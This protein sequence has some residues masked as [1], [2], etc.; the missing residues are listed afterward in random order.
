MAKNIHLIKTPDFNPEKK[1]LHKKIAS[2][3]AHKIKGACNITVVQV[4]TF[5]PQINDHR[6]LCSEPIMFVLSR[7]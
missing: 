5:P 2:P 7:L 4:L 6:L 1:E 3:Q